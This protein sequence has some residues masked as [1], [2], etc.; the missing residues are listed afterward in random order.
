MADAERMHRGTN[1]SVRWMVRDQNGFQAR[2]LDF[3]TRLRLRLRKTF[4]RARTVVLLRQT[5]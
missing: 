5:S 2:R 3:A 1:D 4:S